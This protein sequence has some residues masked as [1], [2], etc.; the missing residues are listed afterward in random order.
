MPYPAHLG[1]STALLTVNIQPVIGE[2]AFKPKTTA[3]QRFSQSGDISSLL[4]LEASY[5]IGYRALS[6]LW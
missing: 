2:I 6:P 5:L 3:R 1:P 4:N